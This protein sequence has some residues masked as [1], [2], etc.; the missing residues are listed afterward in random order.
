MNV[1]RRDFLQASV[2][3]VAF[4]ALGGASAQASAND[5]IRVGVIGVRG[6]GQEHINQ[7]ENH[8]RAQV[9]A[10]CD[11]DENVLSGSLE[12]LNQ[13][14][15]RKNKGYRDLRD[16]IADKEID[17]VATAT[18]NH[19]HALVGIW[20]MREQ[21]DVYVEKPCSHNVREGH[22]LVETAR[23]HGRICQH[24]TQNRSDAS[25][26]EAMEFLH[27]GGIGK[28]HTA[29]GLCYKWRPS[30]GQFS[31]SAPPKSLDW[32]IWQG[33]ASE[34]DFSNLYVHYNWHWFW[35]YGNGDIG[36]QGVHQMDIARWGLGKNCHPNTVFSS[37]G[38]FGYKDGAE[39]PN[40][41]QAIFE[42]DD[43]VL[44]FEV[45]GLPTNDELGVRVGNIWYG[46]QG[47]LVLNGSTWR[48]YRGNKNEVI[49]SNSKKGG[50]HFANFIEAVAA[51]KQS[52]LNAEIEEGHYSSALGH[53]ANIAYRMGR[54][55]HF[56]G[57]TETFANDSAANQLLTRN[58]RRPFDPTA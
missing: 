11:V 3:A 53:L 43:A 49:Q 15:G 45:R 24:G 14:T 54:K 28:V 7:F 6:R 9:V 1:D 29:K 27:K 44:Q 31:K 10:L 13:V 25:V 20:A 52:I 51:R 30:I 21:K 2:G 12:R 39:T 47:Y 48:A 16:L 46:S 57:K 33:P 38:R 18:P 8:P 17:V 36:N 35:E 4:V 22:L 40:T 23:R 50:N 26:R 34:R 37:G 41:Q 42:Y 55:L 56:D 58:Y 32:N 5:V 19:W